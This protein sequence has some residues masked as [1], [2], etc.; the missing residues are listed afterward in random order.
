VHRDRQLEVVGTGTHPRN[1]PH[2]IFGHTHKPYT[3][4]V[5][6]VLFVNAGYVGKSKDGDSRACYVVMDASGTCRVI[7]TR[8]AAP[9]SPAAIKRAPIGKA[10]PLAHDPGMQFSYIY[11]MRVLRALEPHQRV[12]PLRPME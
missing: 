11:L 4:R 3:K 12:K 7:T 9:V 8:A 10:Q 2:L 5:E 6:G 1:F